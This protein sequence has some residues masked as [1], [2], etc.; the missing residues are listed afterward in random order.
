MIFFPSLKQA[1][2]FGMKDFSS[3]HRQQ[4]Q[5]HKIY[6]NIRKMLLASSKFD[7][8]PTGP[9][10][11]KYMS[12]CMTKPTKWHVHTAKTQISLGICP[13]C[14]EFSLSTW[15]K[16]V[17]SATHWAHSEDSDQADLN[18]CWATVIFC[19][20]CHEAAHMMMM[21]HDDF[22]IIIYCF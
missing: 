19:W 12:R 3:N 16:L 10:S 17:F 13:V 1:A 5:G 15:R 22:V 14:S 2:S 21:I 20:F 18:L 9:N 7:T 4:L 8:D 11:I 6:G